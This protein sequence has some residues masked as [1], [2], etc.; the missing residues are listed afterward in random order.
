MARKKEGIEALTAA[1][2]DTDDRFADAI[3]PAMFYLSLAFLV[4]TATLLVLVIDVQRVGELGEAEGGAPSS[5]QPATGTLATSDEAYR[6][7]ALWFGTWVAAVLLL[8]WPIFIAEQ[9]VHFWIAK[10]TQQFEK[11]HPYWWLYCLLPP[12]RMCAR[13]LAKRDLIWFPIGGWHVADYTLQRQ[14]ERAFS[15]PMIWIALLILPV[16]AL[17][18]TLADRIADY[19]ALRFMLHVSAG[20]IWFA[21]A[22]EFIVM[23]SVAER[24]LSYVKQHW[25]D[26]VIILL[27]LVSFLRTLQAL[28]AARLAKL[29]KLHQLSRVVRVYRLRGV[30]MRG[31][32]ALLLLEVAQRIIGSDPQKRIRRLEEQIRWK[33]QEIDFLRAEIE[34]LRALPRPSQQQSDGKAESPAGVPPEVPAVESQQSSG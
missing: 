13:H 22:A 2:T 17:Q 5:E 29:G 6:A 12:M 33:Q 34:Q 21:F 24:K 19:P 26:L 16:L 27:P 18:Y 32:R 28:R 25:L 20:V 8:I 7:S 14:L 9:L 31:F 3:A 4:L 1:A 15:V 23:I 11:R 10:R 30:A